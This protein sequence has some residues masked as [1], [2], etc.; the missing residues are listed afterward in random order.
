[1]A[2]LLNSNDTITT[3]KKLVGKAGVFSTSFFLTHIFRLEKNS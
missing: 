1:M 3:L 2:V